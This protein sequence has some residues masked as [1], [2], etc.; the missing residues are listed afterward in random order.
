MP[1]APLRSITEAF[2]CTPDCPRCHGEGTVC[3]EHPDVAWGDG[4]GCCGAAGMPC[5]PERRHG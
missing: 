4:D 3:E 5:N 1:D 2:T